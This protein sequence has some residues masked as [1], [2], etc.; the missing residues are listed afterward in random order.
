MK[1]G[2]TT[3]F[4][5]STIVTAIYQFII[6]ISG[7]IV[8]RVML[9]A[10]GSEL[11]GLVSSINQFISYFS[12]VEAGL[13]AAIVYSLYEPLATKNQDK[14]NRILSAAKK[15]LLSMRIY[16]YFSSNHIGGDLSTF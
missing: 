7:F 16:I 14:I 10:Y 2:R 8:P 13:A 4:F 12:L 5:Y 9:V 6:M 15:I 11:N 1:T 3:Q